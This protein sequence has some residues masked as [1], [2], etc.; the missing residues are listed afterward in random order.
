MDRR[1]AMEEPVRHP[2]REKKSTTGF[3]QVK[4]SKSMSFHAVDKSVAFPFIS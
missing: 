1:S 3:E 4:Y 2:K